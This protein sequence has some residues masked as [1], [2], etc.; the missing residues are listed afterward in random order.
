VVT[1]P[2]RLAPTWLLDADGEVHPE[3]EADYAVK[4]PR[5]AD[6]AQVER[7]RVDAFAN[8]APEA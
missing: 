5:Q 6:E 1:V 2:R 7:D 8:A 4:G 3:L